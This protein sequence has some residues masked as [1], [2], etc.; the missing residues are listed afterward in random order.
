MTGDRGHPSAVDEP[1]FSSDRDEVVAA[2]EGTRSAVAFL[3]GRLLAVGL[4][5]WSGGGACGVAA[6][7]RICTWASSSVGSLSWGALH[8]CR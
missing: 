4:T 6:A 5:L 1:R 8:L 2:E 7:W 3:S